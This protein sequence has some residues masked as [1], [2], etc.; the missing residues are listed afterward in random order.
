M[1][2]RLQWII[3]PLLLVAG[4]AVFTYLGWLWTRPQGEILTGSVTI[5]YFNELNPYTGGGCTPEKTGPGEFAD[6]KLGTPVVVTDESGKTLDEGGLSAGSDM[7][8]TCVFLFSVGPLKEAASYTITVGERTPVTFTY[9]EMVARDWAVSFD[10]GGQV[11][12]P[13]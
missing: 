12:E 6:L 8:S 10:F 3:L 9:D 4:V 13:E 11:R 5:F 2:S 1:L 7:L